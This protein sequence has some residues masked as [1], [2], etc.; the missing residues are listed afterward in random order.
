MIEIVIPARAASIGSMEVRRVLPFRKR[1]SVGPFIFVDEFGPVE[2]VTDSTLDVLPHPH[3]GLATV[4]YLFSGKM[5]HR[6]SLGTVQVIEPG[7][8]NLMTAGSGIVHSERVSDAGNPEGERLFG[9]QTWLAI[10]EDEEDGD[11]DFNHAPEL[12]SFEIEQG[13]D[14]DLIL[15]DFFGHSATTTS[16]GA[17]YAELQLNE[18]A[19]FEVDGKQEERAVY[20]ISGQIEI[21][22][23][24]YSPGDMPVVA[25][26]SSVV[27]SAASES[28]VMLIGGPA[29]EKPRHML[30]NFVA[31]EKERVLDAA[32]RWKQKEFPDIPNE[33]GY[34]P[35]P[36]YP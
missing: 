25:I 18:G 30:W 35:L 8:V 1:R 34:I 2:T 31:T 20:V 10:S 24:N 11:P 9:L 5:T 7:Q 4:T 28:K 29:L 14:C 19:R 13:V 27:I 23:V 21:E 22:G 16:L 12:P 33:T 26:G 32:E 6:D 15:G 36:D 3:I 17:L